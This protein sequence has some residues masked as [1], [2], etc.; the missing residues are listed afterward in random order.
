MV[1]NATKWMHGCGY[2][3]WIAM[4]YNVKYDTFCA[5]ITHMV[6]TQCVSRA[7]WSDRILRSCCI[8]CFY[9]QIKNPFWQYHDVKSINNKRCMLYTHIVCWIWQTCSIRQNSWKAED[10][11][12]I[13]WICV[14]VLLSLPLFCIASW[15]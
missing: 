14:C 10:N 8:E 6:Y 11:S 4:A 3:S 2:I 12:D 5:K 13:Q 9:C 7:R 15:F 1:W